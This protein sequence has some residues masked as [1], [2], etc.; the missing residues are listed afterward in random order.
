MAQ[1]EVDHII[2]IMKNAAQ[3]QLQQQQLKIEQQRADAATEFEKA[4]IK[5]DQ[6][7]LKQRK[8]EFDANFDLAKKAADVMHMQSMQQVI[9]GLKKGETIPGE[10]ISPAAST[11]PSGEANYTPINPAQ[12]TSEVHQLPYNLGSVTIPTQVEEARRQ[13]KIYEIANAPIE[14]SK[15]KLAKEAEQARSDLA[16]QNKQYDFIRSITQK[17]YD[18]DRADAKNK[19]EMAMKKLELASQERVAKMRA[20]GDTQ[21]HPGIIK[22]AMEG[23]V[24]REDILKMYNQVDQVRI[25]NEILNQGG[26]LLSNKDKELVGDFSQMVQAT[27]YMQDLIANQPQISSEG[28]FARLKSHVAGPYKRLTDSNLAAIEQEI[29]GRSTLIARGFAKEKGNLSNQDIVRAQNML[30]KVS[31]PVDANIKKYN[32]YIMEVDK[33]FRD[34]LSHLPKKQVD[35]LRQKVGLLDVKLYDVGQASATQLPTNQ[36]P[37][38]RRPTLEELRNAK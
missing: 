12:A 18:D 8:A 36:A 25:Q 24:T 9:A 11:L 20:G 4:R 10:T 29:K 2:E 23:D 28:N 19:N 6:E 7:T 5:Q 38:N 14:A 21:I 15:I 32:D 13:A 35:I 22:Q 34:K 31:E 33:A 16:E 27:K 17:I 26:N 1:A 3:K 37:S 30:P